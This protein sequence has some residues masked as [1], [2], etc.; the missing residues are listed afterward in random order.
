MREN[1]KDIYQVLSNDETL[2]RLLYY[3]ADHLDDDVTVASPKRPDVLSLPISDKWEII[4]DVIK[5]IPKVNDLDG[6]KKCRLLFYPSR[7]YSNGS[8]YSSA[9]SIVID[10]LVHM[11]Y[12]NDFR[13]EWI[14]DRVTD[15]L[16]NERITGVGKITFDDGNQ[17][18][19]PADYIGYRLTYSFGSVN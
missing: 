12:E 18:G 3:K 11:D 13:M 4:N 10:V 8:Y 1:M 17:I 14:C 2:L 7:R 6:Q 9:Q 16:S 15:L 5:N 19:T